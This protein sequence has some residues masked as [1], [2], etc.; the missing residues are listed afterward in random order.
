[1]KAGPGL[2]PGRGGAAQHDV[3]NIRVQFSDPA[4]AGEWG[5]AFG[6]DIVAVHLNLLPTG[7]V[8]YWEEGGDSHTGEL[9]DEIRLLHPET[10]TIS[11]PTLPPHDIFCSGHTFLADGRLLVAGGQHAVGPLGSS[12]TSIYNPF[13]NTWSACQEMHGGRWY[14]TTTTLGN[15]DIVVVSGIMDERLINVLPQVWHPDTGACGV[16]RDLTTAQVLAPVNFLYPWMFLLAHGRLFDAG[17]G[18]DTWFLDTSGTGH[19]APGPILRF[20]AARYG[21]SA[22]LYEPSKVLLA[23][24]HS[25]PPTSTAEVID[26]N[27]PR[28]AWRTVVPMA[29]GRRLFNLT[30]LADGTVLATSGTSSPGF[31]VGKRAVYAA[32]RWNPKTEIWTTMTE[33]QLPRVYH[34]T[35]LLL[36]DA[37]V[38]VGGGGSPAAAWDPP[39]EGAFDD[40]RD[41]E[42]YSPPYLFKGP[43]PIIT[44]APTEVR[45]GE[46]AEVDTVDTQRI[47][48][49][50]WIR[51]PSVTH[52]FD[53]NQRISRLSFRRVSGSR[54]AVIL[55]AVANV[56]PPGHYMMFLIDQSGIP[57][58][59]KIMRLRSATPPSKR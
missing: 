14:P 21:G 46:A 24:G 38:L 10:Q 27:Q 11:T 12:A 59:S 29:F 51:L 42:I 58:V 50:T 34:S 56:S 45:Y 49:V 37:R 33:M 18:P 43:R 35:A 6:A 9:V 52:G 36:P 20:G 48:E 5:G 25:A 55:P 3:D 19:W 8:L 1:M 47:A 31:N 44:A 32:E 28:P 23:G 16:W 40:R 15:G 22:V 54:L 39:A 53:A 57:S 30:L 41:F 4:V 26:L 17:P 2:A 13:T 7:Q